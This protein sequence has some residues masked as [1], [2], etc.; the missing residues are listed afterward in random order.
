MDNR[1]TLD[2]LLNIHYNLSGMEISQL[3][4]EKDLNYKIF[5]DK[6][7][8]ILKLM[9]ANCAAQ[10]IDF[11]S[12]FFHHLENQSTHFNCPKIIKTKSSNDYVYV[13]I[14]NQNRILWL[15]SYCTGT[16]LAH[17]KPR[18]KELHSSFGK[19]IAELRTHATGFTHPYMQRAQLWNLSEAGRSQQYATHIIGETNQIAQDVFSKFKVSIKGKLQ[20]LEHGVIHNDAND[21][22][23]LV[24]EQQGSFLVNGIFDFGDMAYQAYICD[25]AIALA[26]AILNQDEPLEV[27]SDFLRAYHKIKPL[28]VEELEILFDLIKTRL[29]VSIA[30]SSK[31]QKESP[32][33]DYITISQEPAKQALVQLNK[34][35]E[36]FALCVFREACGYEIHKGHESIIR[37]LNNEVPFEIIK[38]L[39]TRCVL[40]LSVD[41]KM[42]G[43]NPKNLECD[44]LTH[45]IDEH[46]R[47][48]GAS[49][50]IGRYTEARMIYQGELFGSSNYPA[51]KR[52]KIHM[53]LDVFCAAGT[54]VFAPYDATVII[55]TYNPTPLDYGQVIVLEHNCDDGS[56]FYILYGHLAKKA[57][58]HKGDKI[59]AGTHFASLGKKEEN[60]NWPPH[61]HLQ[62]MTSLLDLNEDF[63]GV[64]HNYE[65]SIW[66]KL[67]P[68]PALLLDKS[69]PELYDADVDKSS[70]LVKR[71]NQL[72]FNLS[73]SYKQP[74][75]A[76]NAY[77]QFIYDNAAQGYLD[78]YNNVPHVGHSHPKVVKAVQDQVGLLNT[79]T[80]YLHE[81]IIRYSEKLLAKF[82]AYLDVCYFVNSASEANELA[83][84]L[85]RTHTGRKDILVN[86]NAYHGHTS[87]LIDISP[88][89]HKGPGG[90]GPP[91]WLH[92]AEAA[93][94]YRGRYKRMDENC[95]L[96]YANEVKTLI[97]NKEI[98]AYI[99]ETYQSVGGQLI[100]PKGYTKSTYA[101]VKENGGVNIADEVQTGFGR[102][103]S[104][105]WGF[106]AQDANPDIVVLGKPIAN[107]MP[108]GAVVTTREIAESFDNGMEFF[109]TFG[110]NPV[111]CAAGEAVLDVMTDEGLMEN[112]H[113]LG[114]EF[115]T[116]LLA[117]KD[118]YE[119]IGDVRAQGFFIGIELVRNKT[120]LEPASTEANYIVN[121][122]KENFILA[123]VDGPFHNVIKLR[124]IMCCDMNDFNFLIQKLELILQ[125]NF[126]C[127]N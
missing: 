24:N 62:I 40:D 105:W 27:C 18:T 103:G 30:I 26:Y 66:K 29:A 48:K 41:S 117:L 61:L 80:R 13:E 5:D 42:L 79:N 19:M 44:S 39:E 53:G 71:K 45:I 111:S 1:Q 104:A 31:R 7:T 2:A 23:V 96:H 35:S 95:G 60:G 37:F 120:S 4:G 116:Q 124:P 74:I 90:Q 17:H 34:I 102:L 70:L 64:V 65:K 98:A 97:K 101:I 58:V 11:Q 12:K 99:S 84:R 68:N 51:S 38:Q 83:L 49:M 47:T 125:E 109:S 87:T 8:F 28:Q 67:C 6:H 22:N 76:V 54:K 114:L 82:P 52:R 15:L 115:K 69:N 14:E 10:L 119:L 92:T 81:N 50:A 110:G 73:L 78:M 122:L 106:E 57:E 43:A 94:D 3:P 63:P 46:L 113:T 108:L 59:K 100:P 32:N 55:K 9:D 85:A 107:G 121:R 25:V 86:E 89:K 21:Y 33:D 77:K 56:P 91:A 118:E 75:H 123:G 36:Q 127:K 20:L 72:G 88:Y 112:A 93:D 16:L 126:L